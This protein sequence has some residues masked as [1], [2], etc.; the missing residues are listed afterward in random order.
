[1]EEVVEV[2]ESETFSEP[3]LSMK[4]KRKLRRSKE[5]EKV[6]LGGEIKYSE[7]DYK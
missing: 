6:T 1:M 5:R 4:E 7:E 3:E 2:N